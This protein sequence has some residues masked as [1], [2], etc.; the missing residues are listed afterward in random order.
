L[1]LFAAVGVSKAVDASNCQP[2]YRSVAAGE[3]IT[4]QV[5]SWRLDFRV[6]LIGCR[7][8]LEEL[9]DDELD[10]L[11][12]ELREPEGWSNLRLINREAAAELRRQVPAQLNE[13]LG[14]PVVT[15]IFY[16]DVHIVDHN[17]Q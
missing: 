8:P 7:E 12:D 5:G 6:A 9:R 10:R 4:A 17:K 11:E 3:P 1:L 16:Y 14:R 2:S 13:V 15:D